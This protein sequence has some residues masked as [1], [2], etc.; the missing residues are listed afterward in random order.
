MIETSDQNELWKKLWAKSDPPH[1][2]W[3]HLLDTAAVCEQLLTYFGSVPG[4]NDHWTMFVAAMHDIGKADPKFQNRSDEAAKALK[5]LGISLPSVDTNDGFR[6]ESRSFEWILDYL[7]QVSKWG[8]DAARVAAYAVKGH[9]GAFDSEGAYRDEDTPDH[10]VWHDLRKV[11]AG[12]VVDCLGLSDELVRP[13][14][15]CDASATGVKLSALIVLSDWIASNCDLFRYPDLSQCLSPRDY[16]REARNQAQTAVGA[17]GLLSNSQSNSGEIPKFCSVWTEIKELRVSQQTLEQECGN[18][19]IPLGLTI[20]E[21]PM[22]EGK[23]ESAIYLA[24]C[25]RSVYGING[26]YIAL[27]TMATSNQMHERYAR[28]LS[29]YRLGSTGP[30]LT[31]G[32]AW[33]M[34]GVVPDRQPEIYGDSVPDDST[35]AWNWF[36]PSK[37]A[38]IAPEA[39]GTI[40][41]ALMAA[42]HVKHG[43]LRLF[44]LASKVLIIDEVHAYDDYMT[45]ILERLL[46]WCKALRIP[47]VMLSATLSRP[48]KERLLRAYGADISSIQMSDCYPLITVLP[49]DAPRIVRSVAVRQQSQRCIGL[50]THYGIIDDAKNTAELATKLVSK[51]GCVCV[52]VNTVKQAQEVYKNLNSFKG[53]RFLFHARFT[54]SRRSEIESDIV[55]LFGKSGVGTHKRPKQAVLVATQVVEQSLDLDF[56]VMITQ[57]AP[58]DLL[59]QRC[60]RVWRHSG[61]PR[62]SGCKGPVLHVL[63]PDRAG[64]VLGPSK[65]VYHEAM[66]LRTMVLLEDKSELSLPSDLRTLVDK[67]YGDDELHSSK[68]A[69]IRSAEEDW[70]RRKADCSDQASKYLIRSPN[71]KEF[72]L[73]YQRQPYDEDDE[74]SNSFFHA[75]TRLGDRTCSVILVEDSKTLNVACQDH[76]PGRDVLKELYLQKVDIPRRWLEG[77]Q[78]VDGYERIHEGI[79]WLRG[80]KVILLSD[81]CWKGRI[82]ETHFRLTNNQE[83]GVCYEMEASV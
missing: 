15:L 3:R 45:T 51:G 29:G 11:L 6:H 55:E 52:L 19:G 70:R 18:N 58:I 53:K 61:T 41:Q 76:Y 16:W 5:A 66:L 17:L 56:D 54:A 7:Q 71:A 14:D 28:F 2:L 10:G 32:M 27:P 67:C 26:T 77:A 47:V 22:G 73:A 1:P 83:L 13:D 21:A 12:I 40:D 36:T 60:G 35:F 34:D 46:E 62:P 25:W 23:T 81:G 64:S 8:K 9:H 82:G 20:I 59:F 43:F 31:H 69:D 80:T 38:L 68:I 75:K 65:T 4:L 49:R 50:V 63:M 72:S 37:R 74:S 30:R 78:P 48:Q 57:L 33:L 39:V 79:K 44:G 24:E 42:L